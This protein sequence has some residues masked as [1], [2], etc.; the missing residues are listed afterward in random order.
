MLHRG[1]TSFNHSTNRIAIGSAAFATLAAVPSSD[2]QTLQTTQ[3]VTRVAVGRRNV[4]QRGRIIPSLSITLFL[5]CSSAVV[6]PRVGH[7][8]DV[9][10]PFIFSPLS[11]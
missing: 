5:F 9:L 6:D 7:T 8:M 3:R 4:V 11:F 1:T 2:K 10:S